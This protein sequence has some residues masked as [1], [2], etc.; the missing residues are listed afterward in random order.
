MNWMDQIGDLFQQYTSGTSAPE[1]AGDHYGQVAEVAPSPTVAAGLADAMRSDQTP[2]FAQLA[3]Q[4]FSNSNG[5]Q[6]A[7]MLKELLATVGPVLPQALGSSV[8]GGLLSQLLG[9]GRPVTAQD[10]QEIPPEAVQE[11]AQRANNQD[12]SIIDRVSSMYAEHP[13]VVKTLGAGV[14]SIA[15]AKISERMRA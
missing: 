1:Q 9:S 6:K 5:E 2:P 14:L 12:A 8:A 10:A 11:L 7:N 4:L 3:A 13:T 15:L